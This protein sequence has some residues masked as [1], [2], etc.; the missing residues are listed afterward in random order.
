LGTIIGQLYPAPTA[1][2]NEFNT[3]YLT[4]SGRFRLECLAAASR[5]YH[6]AGDGALG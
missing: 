3:T 1:V 4:V 2:T 6:F 5:I